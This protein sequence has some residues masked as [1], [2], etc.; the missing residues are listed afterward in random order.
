MQ[1]A[2]DGRDCGK[3]INAPDGFGKRAK[4]EPSWAGSVRLS[5]VSDRH[6]S[7]VAAVPTS[8]GNRTPIRFRRNRRN[9][10][11]LRQRP[12]PRAAHALQLMRADRQESASDDADCQSVHLPPPVLRIAEIWD[13]LPPHIREAIQTLVDAASPDDRDREL[14]EVISNG[15]ASV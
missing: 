5:G 14:F 11:Q 13:R 15:L 9:P 12:T 4:D 8:R 7:V 1:T 10:L 6:P 2:N 3:S